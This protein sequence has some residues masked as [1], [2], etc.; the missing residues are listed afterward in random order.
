MNDTTKLEFTVDTD[1]SSSGERFLLVMSKTAVSSGTALEPMTQGI[2]VRAYPNPL[3]GSTP[4][5]VAIDP[6][7]APWSLRLVDISGRTIWLRSGV[8]G[9]DRTVEIDMSARA[10]GIYHLETTDGRGNRSVS[11]VVKQ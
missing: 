8:E 9:S 1:E 6:E 3:T 11:K 4:L 2:G 7:R 5:R 10:A